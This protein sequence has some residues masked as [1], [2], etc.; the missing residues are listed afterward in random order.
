VKTCFIDEDGIIRETKIGAFVK[1]AD[2]EQ[3]LLKL[4]MKDELQGGL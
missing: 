4:M 3:S 1:R 2:I